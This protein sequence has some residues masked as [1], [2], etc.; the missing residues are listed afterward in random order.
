MKQSQVKEY[1][2]AKDE[3]Y[4]SL[5]HKFSYPNIFLVL[6]NA[7]YEIRHSNFLK[8]LLDPN[9][10]HG[11]GDLFLVEFLQRVGCK[12]DDTSKV[13]LAREYH[14]I[15]L[16]IL[17]ESVA[18][19]IENKTKTQDSVGQL[20]KYRELMK[21]DFPKHQHHYIY[22]T[23][24]GEAPLDAKEAT[25]WKTYSHLDFV[26][27]LA[28]GSDQ[29]Q[30]TKAKS[31]IQDYVEALQLNL[32]PESDYTTLGKAL[33]ARHRK[34]FGEVF[35]AV[36]D[37]NP[38]KST[39]GFDAP[40]VATLRFLARNSSFVK[41][42]GFFSPEKPFLKAFEK[43]LEVFGYRPTPRGPKQSTYL[44]F[45]PNDLWAVCYRAGSLDLKAFAFSFRYFDKK[46]L[47]LTFGVD[48]PCPENKLLRDTVLAHTNVFHKSGF[49][50]PAKNPG[51]KHVGILKLK[52]PFDPMAVDASEIDQYVADIFDRDVKH[53]VNGV[54][55]LLQEILK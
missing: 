29:L 42:K 40:D 55:K 15:D 1:Q 11:H 47:D 4:Q 46:Y 7:N 19:A 34:E 41:G 8:W 50:I 6:D 44:G 17:D 26:G 51:E 21:K 22:W 52:I 33:V 16:L 48:A 27:V 36:S 23:V 30:N 35:L 20:E 32:L 39:V 3:A 28:R 53:F 24:K 38:K 14:G 37:R 9:E 13:Q 5:R 31:Y 18:I 10:I 25:H 2:F 12:F 54:S 43:S 45:L 49:G